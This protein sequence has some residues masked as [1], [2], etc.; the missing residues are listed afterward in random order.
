MRTGQGEGRLD[1]RI[2][3]SHHQLV[4]W[5]IIGEQNVPVQRVAE[6]A[7]PLRPQTV[8]SSGQGMALE[9]GRR[10]P[11]IQPAGGPRQVPACITGAGLCGLV[12]RRLCVQAS[13]PPTWLPQVAG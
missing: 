1:Q 9:S 6:N 7:F 2:L 3:A 12:L 8:W 4:V 5:V 10:G 13:P 11:S